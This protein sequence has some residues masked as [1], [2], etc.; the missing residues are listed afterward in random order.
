M[1]ISK[2]KQINRTKSPMP[3]PFTSFFLAHPKT[4]IEDKHAQRQPEVL[5]L[6]L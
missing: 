5:T 1:F 2:S 3:N 6:S 4:T